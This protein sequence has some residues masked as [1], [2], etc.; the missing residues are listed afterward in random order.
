MKFIFYYIASIVFFLYTTLTAGAPPVTNT[1]VIIIKTQ[2]SSGRGPM[3]AP[4]PKRGRGRSPSPR[5][6][7]GPSPRRG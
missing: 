6:G 4:S 5:R 7:R 1:K 3:R 2:T